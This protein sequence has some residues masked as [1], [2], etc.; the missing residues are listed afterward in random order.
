MAGTKIKIFELAKELDLEAKAVLMQLR[1]AGLGVKSASSTVDKDEA[2]M[3]LGKGGNN[4]P[5]P[6]A[7]ALPPR[8][9]L[10]PQAPAAMA[11]PKPPVAKVIK[12]AAPIPEKRTGRLGSTL[13]VV[14]PGVTRPAPGTVP[15]ERRPDG[16]SGPAGP[17][18]PPRAGGPRGQVGRRPPM[19][20]TPPPPLATPGK[21]GAEAGAGRTAAKKG[22][23]KK[24]FFKLPP[25]KKREGSTSLLG[26]HASAA[27]SASSAV[28]DMSERVLVIRGNMTVKDIS[29]SLGIPAKDIITWLFKD[30][31][32]P[33][34]INHTVD[35]DTSQLIAEHFGAQ[36]AHK[37]KESAGDEARLE[38]EDDATL[39]K[40]RAPI[41]T[42]MGHVD[43]GKTKLLDAIRNAR[44]AEG[45]AG[46]ITQH[47]GAYQVTHK[48]KPITFLDTPGH[49]AFTQMRARGAN[50]TDVA[51]LVVAAD[52]GVMPQTIEALNHARSAKVPVLVALN[53]IDKPG[54]N[55]DRVMQQLSE[56]GLQPE[57]WGGDT[58]FVKVSALK[59]TGIEQLLE[60]ILLMVEIQ[61]LKAN[62][63]RFAVGTIIEAYLDKA[64]GP[65]ATVLVQKGTLRP[66]DSAVAGLCRAK[67][68]LMLDDHGNPL[69]EAGPST[70]VKI[71]GL[72]EV[73]QAG[74]P[75]YV[76][77]DEKLAKDIVSNRK[78]VAKETQ[79]AAK[80]KTTL[81]ELFSQIE[82]GAAKELRL[83]IKGD[84]QGSV[85]AL[86]DS[87]EKI[88]SKE[89]NVRIIHN[90]VGAVTE[91][92]INLAAASDAIIVAFNIPTPAAIKRVATNEQ[93]E[94]REYNVIYDVIE[95]VK[96]AMLGL[97][98][99][100]MEER[101]TGEAE[102]RAVFSFSRV[103]K[104]AGCYMREGKARRNSLLRIYRGKD[105]AQ[106]FKGNVES[107]KRFKDDVSEVQLGYE[108]GIVVKDFNDF[109][110]GDVF[111]FFEMVA[112]ERKALA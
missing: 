40:P 87:L 52:D 36:F 71:T 104:I 9:P 67:V 26:S 98:S 53:K 41:V 28:V 55:P 89:V 44:V 86:K 106:I 74:D 45:E 21:P 33:V 77:A 31:G 103:G 13:K 37:L 112:V 72:T 96:A 64:H 81:A 84:V 16:R 58:V 49:E 93:V 24:K 56:L 22:V 8:P 83:I 54:V 35:P 94:L 99:P 6:G 61:D 65:T 107:L 30:M 80:R 4:T 102:V 78:L 100:D 18:G 90:Q 15:A 85:E 108:C 60:M 29:A 38:V 79:L 82:E 97:L 73:P 1:D 34:T 7:E 88:E 101:I 32:I 43:H 19:G 42:V 12:K 70:P 50:V 63:D 69:Q 47:I 5:S 11:P 109:E 20:G 57:E 23:Q 51:V 62:P 92:D 95:D 66:G 25:K 39:L 10:R 27:T 105:R 110:E 48:G 46:G 14:T 76:V 111:E 2:M 91:N 17:G 75:L 59:A 3:C 68:R